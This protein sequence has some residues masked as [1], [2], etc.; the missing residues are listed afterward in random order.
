MEEHFSTDFL[1]DRGID[2]IREQVSKDK[3]F[4][5][6]LS[7]PGETFLMNFVATRIQH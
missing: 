2:F 3:P 5:L 1:F 7:I 4:A 6:V